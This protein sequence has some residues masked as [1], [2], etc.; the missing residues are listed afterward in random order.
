MTA[1]NDTNR[2]LWSIIIPN[3]AHHVDLMFSTDADP[4]DLK[5]ARDF[6]LARIKEWVGGNIEPQKVRA[7]RSTDLPP[8]GPPPP[9]YPQITKTVHV[10]NSCHLDI[11][12]ADS[13]AN[14]INRYFDDHIPRALSVA[15]ELRA[16]SAAGLDGLGFMFQSWVL[17]FT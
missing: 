1:I 15:E 5:V 14:I 9:V 16:S 11:G 17:S 6:E 2:S 8:P 13:A 12:F 4:P 7:V 3:G 10:I